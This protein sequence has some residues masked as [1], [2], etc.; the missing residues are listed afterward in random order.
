MS[1][2]SY[3]GLKDNKIKASHEMQSATLNALF[4]TFA[5]I[6]F[7]PNGII[8]TARA[9]EHGRGFAVVAGEVRALAQ[10]SAEAAK[11]IKGLMSESVERIDEGMALAAES[12]KVLDEINDAI[13]VVAS[14]IHQI[15]QTSGD[16]S[17][18]IRQVH[19]AIA[20]IDQVTQQNAA[21]VEETS[22][23][24]ESLDQ[25]AQALQKDMAFFKT[26]T[27]VD[28]VKIKHIGMNE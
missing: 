17:E 11:D 4:K 21:L 19:N 26:N 18:G 9:G 14:L 5:T 23:A 20:Q 15:A 27:K 22:D 6:E 3:V 24:S 13:S 10:K 16:Q 8:E 7:T 1:L 28:L 2:F 25:Q 12:G